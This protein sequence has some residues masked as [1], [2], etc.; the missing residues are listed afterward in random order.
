MISKNIIKLY[1]RSLCTVGLGIFVL[2]L[3]SINC[4]K[5]ELIEKIGSQS[6]YTEDFQTYYNDD[7]ESLNYTT[8]VSRKDVGE[9]VCRGQSELIQA[10]EP[11]E[12][13]EGYRDSLM[14]AQVAKK[15]GFL[16]EPIVKHML[17]KQRLETIKNLYTTS[18]LITKVKATPISDK[19]KEEYCKALRKEK[20]KETAGITAEQCLALGERLAIRELTKA[21]APEVINEIRESVAISANKEL[22][23]D[24]Y[25]SPIEFPPFVELLE[26]GGCYD[27]L[28]K[29]VDEAENSEKNSES[30]KEEA[31]K[32]DTS[33]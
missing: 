19:V 16:D 28:K 14:V 26:L 6:I 5:G 4:K 25:F 24:D 8:K 7:V 20:P 22:D 33:K 3:S 17:R 12:S 18:K 10:L 15:E 29:S 21:R 23:K 31:K 27:E 30:E 2:A 9:A 13:Y 32:A 1:F 11:S